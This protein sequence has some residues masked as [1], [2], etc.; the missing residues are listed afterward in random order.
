MSKLTRKEVWYY[1]R[2]I[3]IWKN[4]FITFSYK[5]RWFGFSSPLIHFSI[6]R[7]FIIIRVNKIIYAR[8]ISEKID[9]Y[10]YLKKDNRYRLI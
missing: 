4:I 5:A 7:W 8:G 1:F 3:E 6:G 2:E 10:K 9:V